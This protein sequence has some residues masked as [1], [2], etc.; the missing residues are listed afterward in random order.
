MTSAEKKRLVGTN[1]ALWVIAILVSFIL[2]MVAESITD[3]RAAFLKAMAHVF[4]LLAAIPIST[5]IISKSVGEP[6]D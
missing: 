1:A 5:G 2:P 6:T 3:G 4:P